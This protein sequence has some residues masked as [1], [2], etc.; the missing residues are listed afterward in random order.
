M[1]N[2]E[3]EL[4]ETSDQENEEIDLDQHRQPVEGMET[5]DAP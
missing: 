5:E 1:S 4:T 2:S 3:L